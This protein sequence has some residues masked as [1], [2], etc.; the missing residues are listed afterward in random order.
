M[1][2]MNKSLK[3]TMKCNTKKR[4]NLKFS[5]ILSR[6]TLCCCSYVISLIISPT[7]KNFIKDSY[8]RQQTA[9]SKVSERCRRTFKMI[10]E[11]LEFSFIYKK[12]EWSALK[13]SIES[14]SE[15]IYFSIF[16]L[17]FFRVIFF[18][19]GIKVIH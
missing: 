4:N 16:I 3:A 19:S 9:I 6:I 11:S 8:T 14:A 15:S 2:F 7:L 10:Q 1:H 18:L 5:F 12:I 13:S 17:F